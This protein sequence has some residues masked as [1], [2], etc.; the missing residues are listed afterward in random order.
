MEEFALSACD[1]TCRIFLYKLRIGYDQKVVEALKDVWDADDPD[2]ILL[3]CFGEWDVAAITKGVAP[4]VALRHE[5]TIPHILSAVEVAC[6]EICL[7]ASPFTAFR[8]GELISLT[9]VRL[10]R[11]NSDE[12]MAERGFLEWWQSRGHAADP[13]LMLLSTL[14]GPQF[15]VVR[16][17]KDLA[18]FS[19]WMETSSMSMPHLRGTYSILTLTDDTSAGT[20]GGDSPLLGWL[21][22]NAV[23]Q[24]RMSW[25]ARSRNEVHEL[26]R[27]YFVEDGPVPS[28]DWIQL[29]QHAGARDFTLSLSDPQNGASDSGAS[30]LP[31]LGVTQAMFRFRTGARSAIFATETSIQM[32]YLETTS[33]ESTP[34]GDFF[35]FFAHLKNSEAKRIDSLDEVGHR[36][37]Q[38]LYCFSDLL[39]DEA[40]AEDLADAAMCWH[41]IKKVAL[42]LYDIQATYPNPGAAIP[43]LRRLA[44]LVYLVQD[45][46]HQRLLGPTGPALAMMSSLPRPIG[47]VNRI[48]QAA[49]AVPM[50]VIAEMADREKSGLQNWA[51]IIN[52]GPFRDYHAT[53]Y[54]V[55]S[56]PESYLLRPNRWIGLIHE[57]LHCFFWDN[58]GRFDPDFVKLGRNLDIGFGF[59]ELLVD[60]FDLRFSPFW[61]THLWFQHFWL[62]VEELVSNSAPAAGFD[63]AVIRCVFAWYHLNS[64]R[65]TPEVSLIEA[66]GALGHHYGIWQR[67]AEDDGDE[68]LANLWSRALKRHLR[69]TG[70]LQWDSRMGM[71]SDPDCFAKAMHRVLGQHLPFDN[72]RIGERQ[73]W[74][75]GTDLDVLLKPDGLFGEIEIHEPAL[76]LWK[77][78]CH[79]WGEDEEIPPPQRI[80][81]IGA[82]LKLFRG[83]IRRFFTGTQN[84]A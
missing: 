43:G 49:T 41:R 72:R 9:L 58:I 76:F 64:F 16:N 29:Y 33:Q 27:K 78:W 11:F 66:T 8:R 82:L 69:V 45:G 42:T 84:P 80:I 1:D 2:V 3:H 55:I 15:V 38:F 73:L 46:V 60:Y 25:D 47:S 54:S 35:P 24:F 68:K 26:A 75:N 6:D 18:D 71:E 17:N 31:L 39:D 13:K 53:S 52:L 62:H 34:P 70:E 19:D 20:A 30:P 61:I 36:V 63:N 79:D 81:V 12:K 48:L 14:G 28:E 37:L 77:L 32:P 67:A 65:D 51:G 10:E 23:V 40:I 22:T 7:G 50:L 56:L 5:G 74:W 44:E 59:H 4:R 21:P 83:R 57:S